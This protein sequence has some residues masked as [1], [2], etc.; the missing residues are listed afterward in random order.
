MTARYFPSGGTVVGGTVSSD[1]VV[2]TVVGAVGAS[3]TGGSVTGAPVA[4]GTV[5]AVLS[6]GGS[7]GTQPASHKTAVAKI[8]K[9]V[10]FI[11]CR[12]LFFY[13]TTGQQILQSSPKM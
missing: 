10:L 4:E 13:C 5:P 9:N 12:L 3:V 2:G 1:V 8:N 7:A 6:A 11:L